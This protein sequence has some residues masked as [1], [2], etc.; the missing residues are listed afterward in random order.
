M[1]KL[2]K[3]ATIDIPAWIKGLKVEDAVNVVD[4]EAAIKDMAYVDRIF[5]QG[6]ESRSGD[7]KGRFIVEVNNRY[8]GSDGRRIGI[9]PHSREVSSTGDGRW[10]I[11]PMTDDEKENEEKRCIIAYVTED[12]GYDEWYNLSLEDLKTIFQKATGRDW[13]KER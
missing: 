13:D 4:D 10:R 6:F 2:K 12:I 9:K 8:Y 5:P 11:E 3:Q 1:K 7:F